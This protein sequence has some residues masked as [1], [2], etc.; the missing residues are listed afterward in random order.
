MNR[1]LHRRPG[2]LG[3]A[4]LIFACSLVVR[5]VALSRLAS[6]PFLL[7]SKGDMYFYND[8]AQRI[9]QGQLTDHQAFYGLPLY[10]YLLAFLYKLF[11]YS[12]FVPGFLQAVLEAGTATLIYKI[13][14][15]VFEFENP[16][17]VSGTGERSWIG[18]N[19]SRIIG[20]LA[21]LGWA[22][23]VPAQAYSII[24]MPTSWLIFVFWFL[25]WQV[26]RTN[27]A[28]GKWRSFLFGLL[29]GF[30]AMGIAT[31]LFIVPLVLV[32]IGWRAIKGGLT[33]RITAIALLFVG[34]GTGSSPC[35]LHNLL[36]AHDRVA[37]SAHS[38]INF[39]I[40]NNP[41]ANGYP[42]FPP[43][44]RAGQAAMLQDSIDV[45]EAAAGRPLKRSEVSAY[46][47]SKA[48][49]FIRDNPGAWLKLVGRKV[50]NFW[51]AFQYDDLSIV[52]NLR[53]QGIILPGPRFGLIA[54]LALSGMLLA[55]G[56]FRRSRWVVAAIFLHMASLLSV[57]VTERY[58]L[59]AV[60]G[61]LLFASFG[62][63]QA[64]LDCSLGR[65]R[66]VALYLGAMAAATLFVSMPQKNPSLWALDAYNSGWQA[67]ESHNLPL[68]SIE[69]WSRKLTPLECNG[70]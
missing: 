26:V 67:L 13:A 70:L 47:S 33:A 66:R 54:A 1:F 49:D 56:R 52:T 23:F 55:V 3:F 18:Q 30:T 9:L 28:P 39:W 50:V 42:R 29:I 17:T 12:P 7:P 2:S 45:A 58:R 60:P 27:A 20:G 14:T 38:G 11:G 15:R 43:G 69:A 37:L 53:E 64:W 10:P 21:S 57:F 62:I 19:M 31:I 16:S 35:W 41:I 32:A 6:S 22:F 34:L 68:T 59:A 48:K 25:V 36:I 40:G 44:L 46:W 63:C 65:F 4:H 5:L 51:N 24:L 61:L 8:W